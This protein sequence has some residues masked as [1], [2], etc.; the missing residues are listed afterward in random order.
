MAFEGEFDGAALATSCEGPGDCGERWLL[1]FQHVELMVG[2]RAGLT[3]ACF[4]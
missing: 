1:W 3:W 2:D 4:G